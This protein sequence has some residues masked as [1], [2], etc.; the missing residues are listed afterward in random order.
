MILKN[1]FYLF[2]SVIRQKDYLFWFLA[3]PI[4][5][6]V[7]LVTIFSSTTD[8][9][10]I[11][12][13]LYLIKP[14]QGEFSNIIYDVFNNLSSGENKIFDLK[15]FNSISSKDNMLSDLKSEKVNGIVEI[16]KGFDAALLSNFAFKS[17]GLSF[18]P[19]TIKIYSLKH[20]TTSQTASLIVKNIFE[21][22]DLE[23]AKRMKDIKEYE[24]E[25]EIVGTKETF[26][27][28]DFLYPGILILAI[29]FTGLLGIGSELAWYKEGKIYKRLHVTSLSP[30]SFFSSFFLSRAYFIIIQI[31]VVSAICKFVYKSTINPFNPAFLFYMFLST[32]TFCAM[33][34]FI[35]AV[36]KSANSAGIVGQILQF[37]MQFLGGI[38]F[39]VQGVPWFIKWIVLINPITYL[40]DGVRGSLGIMSS[41]YPKF[42]SVLV[43]LIYIV[44]FL[45]IALKKYMVSE[46]S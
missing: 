19:P 20:S 29:F 24:V 9:E 39:P 14:E 2:K 22:F 27:Y 17:F 16:P 3:F 43:P 42:L 13:S 15:V 46:F 8:V 44:I 1:S 12:L 21:R 34:F 11:N 45:Y 32:V 5:L 18:E 35:S 41:T 37:P 38:Y 33:G 31:V 23:F 25:T 36:S 30:I 26:S 6:L 28:V 40:C 7:I 10:R 4:V